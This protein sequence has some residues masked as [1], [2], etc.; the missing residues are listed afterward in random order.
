MAVGTR[1]APCH[2]DVILLLYAGSSSIKFS[3]FA[4]DPGAPG[5]ALRYR[6]AIER[7]E[8]D[9]RFFVADADGRRVVDHAVA[10][11]R[12]SAGAHEAV[13]PVRRE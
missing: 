9:P 7:L 6:G 10:G 4:V 13:L 5:L 1:S 11:R 3:I 12:L 8:S 2:D